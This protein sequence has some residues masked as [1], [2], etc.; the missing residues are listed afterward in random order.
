MNT[1][2]TNQPLELALTVSPRTVSTVRRFIEDFVA[3]A[4][5]RLGADLNLSARVA[6][7]IHE[8]L[9]SV[10]LYGQHRH[11]TLHLSAT[12]PRGPRRLTITVT[13]TAAAEHINRLKQAIR[14]TVDASDAMTHYLTLM[15]REG[16]QDDSGLGLARI[17]AEA[18]MQLSLAVDKEE[19]RVSATSETF[20]ETLGSGGEM[21][22]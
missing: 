1:G 2:G 17:R 21:G 10:A 12:A 9:E 22:S 6:L 4:A 5:G 19:V 20:G 11:G 8:L 15:R 7:T 3:E 16:G 14:N 13:N 18:D